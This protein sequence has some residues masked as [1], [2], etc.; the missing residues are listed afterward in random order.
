MGDTNLDLLK[1]AH[2]N[3]S[4]DFLLSLLS[5][6][7][8]PF[9]DKPTCVYKNSATLIDNIFVSN[10]EDVSFGG[11]IISD[12]SDHFA[13]FCLLK[14]AKDLTCITRKKVR[15]FSAFSGELFK[16]DICSVD[17][18]RFFQTE[19]NNIDKELSTF[20]KTLNKIVN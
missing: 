7:L 18:N 6:Y 2:D 20:Y 14:T 11:N 8:I 13:Q 12:I 5:C 4:H 19:R 17:W 16:K 9:I 10:P 3:F 15:N 1:S